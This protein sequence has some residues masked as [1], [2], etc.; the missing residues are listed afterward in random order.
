VF[1]NSI[2]IEKECFCA[3]GS[4][5][6]NPEAVLLQEFLINSAS[7]SLAMFP[8]YEPSG[9]ASKQ[10]RCCQHTRPVCTVFLCEGGHVE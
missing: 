3:F 2:L 6:I 5:P 8:N 9:W 7:R 4:K 1:W 10:C